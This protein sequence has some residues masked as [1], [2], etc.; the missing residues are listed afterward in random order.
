MLKNKIQPS[1]FEDLI[2]FIKQF[3]N[4]EASHLATAGSHRRDVQVEVVTDWKKV[5]LRSQEWILPGKD[6]FP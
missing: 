4:R 5:G 2:G 1:K 6:T 3:M